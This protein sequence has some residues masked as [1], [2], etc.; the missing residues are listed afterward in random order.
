METLIRKANSDDAPAITEILHG[1]GYFSEI[2]PASI[3]DTKTLII[4]NMEICKADASH[5]T[6]VAQD[7][8]GLVIGFVSAHWNPYLFFPGPEGYISELFVHAEAR[9]NG[10]G[11]KLLDIVKTEARERGCYRLMLLNMRKRESYLRDFYKKDG[12]EERVDVANF[13]YKL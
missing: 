11:T 3:S 6:Y 4:K 1:L 2:L 13:I 7:E 9:G 10:V 12:W 5:S 8:K